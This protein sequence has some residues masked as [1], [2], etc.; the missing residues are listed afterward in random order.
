M[1]RLTLTLASLLLAG[2]AFGADQTLP[3][4]VQ[5]ALT[6]A[7]KEITTNRTAYDAANRKS[8]DVTEKALKAEL[9]KQTKTGNLEVALEIKKLLESFRDTTVAKV[10]Q[11]AREDAGR[12]LLGE[13]PEKKGDGNKLKEWIVG[14]KYLMNGNPKDPLVF[15]ANGIMDLPSQW[16]NRNGATWECTDKNIITIVANGDTYVLKFSND[17]KS[18]TSV[19]NGTATETGV[20]AK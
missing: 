16:T 5:N 8:L 10:D 9:D 4:S 14:K 18:Y 17:C 2:V 15:Q 6:K 13:K 11:K 1:P 7:E 12:D 20:L 3:D 19:R